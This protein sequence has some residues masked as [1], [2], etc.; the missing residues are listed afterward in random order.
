MVAGCWARAQDQLS[1]L[2][3]LVLCRNELTSFRGSTSRWRCAPGVP[4]HGVS[5]FV[6]Q[7]DPFVQEPGAIAAYTLPTLSTMYNT[8]QRTLP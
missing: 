8:H 5:R 1:A 3:C 6:Q 4:G 7:L 2:R